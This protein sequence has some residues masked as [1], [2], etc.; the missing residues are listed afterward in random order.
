MYVYNF[1]RR[2]NFYSDKWF[3]FKIIVFLINKQK[4]TK[5]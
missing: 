2:S 5:A 4:I 1:A 3:D